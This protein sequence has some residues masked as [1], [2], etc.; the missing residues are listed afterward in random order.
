MWKKNKWR[1]SPRTGVVNCTCHGIVTGNGGVTVSA[2]SDSGGT[3][4]RRHWVFGN[5]LPIPGIGNGLWSLSIGLVALKNPFPSSPVSP[6]TLDTTS[7]FRAARP[8]PLAFLQH[9][10]VNLLA[11]MPMSIP[12]PECT[13]H[14][15]L[16]PSQTVCHQE[17]T[18]ED[19]T[20]H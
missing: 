3:D 10:N 19:I 7:S 16:T 11:K 2:D 5:P 18:C 12:P 14:E 20:P 8:Q 6:L 1:T 9:A 13:T 17:K 4:R 15:P